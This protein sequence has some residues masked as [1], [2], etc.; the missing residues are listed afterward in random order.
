M[1]N[2]IIDVALKKRSKT[3][4]SK[5]GKCK[6]QRTSKSISIKIDNDDKDLKV[7]IRIYSDNSNDSDDSNDWNDFNDSN[8]WNDSNNS[9]DWNDCN[10]GTECDN[11]NLAPGIYDTFG[12]NNIPDQ[13][14]RSS[15]FDIVTVPE[16]TNNDNILLDTY[17]TYDTYDTS[18]TLHTPEEIDSET[19]LF[20]N[21]FG[22]PYD[23]D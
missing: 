23:L 3:R 10:D 11:N 16:E 1:S 17:D 7:K 6:R 9:N 13:I 22:S 18:G 2:N 19:M 20:N 8:D 21:V 4:S 5:Y 14:G 15:T 12:P